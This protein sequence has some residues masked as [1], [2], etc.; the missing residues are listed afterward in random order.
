[1]T[2]Y[3]FKIIT[4]LGGLSL[5]LFGMDVMGKA[6]ERQAGGK[7]QTILAKMSSNVFKGF[8]LGLGV[9]AVIQSSSAT[10][11][12]VVGFVNSGI[13]TLKQQILDMEADVRTAQELERENQRYEQLLGIKD[14]HEDYVL[15][16]AYIIS[17]DASSY[18]S[19]FTIGKGTNH[20]LQAGMIAITENGQ[21]VGLITDIGVN[22]ATITT[23]LDNGLEISASIAASGYT[24]VV[25]G[26]YQSE[27][28]RMLRM[29]YLTSEAIIKNGDQVVTTGSTQY[30]KGLLLGHIT[31][32]SMDETGVA[33]YAALQ[34][35]CALDDLEQIFVITDYENE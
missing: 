2:A 19:S 5:F 7:L 4:L 11:V 15:Q 20:G 27:N 34:A 32:V 14:E 23:I 29:N 13:M 1:M 33:K 12:M 3:I 25:Q 9:T 24:G 17:W 21:V 31:N 8:L 10:T 18:R 26:T 35:S 6:L 16:P 22:W 28:T 30:P